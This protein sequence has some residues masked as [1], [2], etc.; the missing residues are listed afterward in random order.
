MTWLDLIVRLI[1]I[2]E[3]KF[4]DRKCQWH[5]PQIKLH[6]IPIFIIVV[7]IRNVWFSVNVYSTKMA[8][9]LNELIAMHTNLEGRRKKP[10]IISSSHMHI[11]HLQ[12]THKLVISLQC[13]NSNNITKTDAYCF[14]YVFVGFCAGVFN[15]NRRLLLLRRRLWYII[16]KHF[17]HTHTLCCARSVCALVHLF[18]L[19]GH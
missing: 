5:S 9:L 11:C 17:Y 6:E 19:I 2:V 8:R 10:T 18:F 13:T 15:A 3:L 7:L 16:W 12:F 4:L 14:S 1:S